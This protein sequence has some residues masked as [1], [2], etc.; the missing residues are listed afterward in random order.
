[1]LA[2]LFWAIIYVC[3]DYHDIHNDPQLVSIRMSKFQAKLEDTLGSA[4]NSVIDR[5]DTVEYRQEASVEELHNRATEYLEDKQARLQEKI[6]SKSTMQQV[7][8]FLLKALICLAAP[9]AGYYAMVLISQNIESPFRISPNIASA[10][11]FIIALLIVNIKNP[12][13]VIIYEWIRLVLL[14]ILGLIACIFLAAIMQHFLVLVS[15]GRYSPFRAS[16]N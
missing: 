1:M 3:D 7:L 4:I 15:G 16:L 11:C 9:V 12:E 13:W 5:K 6:E 14:C 10:V 2:L 8:S